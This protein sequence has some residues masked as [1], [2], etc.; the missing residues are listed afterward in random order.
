MCFCRIYNRRP[1][2]S[3]KMSPNQFL[4][5]PLKL[6]FQRESSLKKFNYEE[7]KRKIDEE[8]KKSLKRVHLFSPVR[9]SVKKTRTWQKEATRL[10]YFSE[11]FFIYQFKRNMLPNFPI[12]VKLCDLKCKIL[13][14]SFD[15]NSLK[16]L[17]FK[18]LPFIIKSFEAKKIIDAN[19][20]FV[21][22]IA[23][24]KQKHFLIPETDLKYFQTSK[25]LKKWTFQ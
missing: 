5:E 20:Y 22:K 3:L 12:L 6:A 17:K 7:N 19:T 16:I 13:P 1:H 23:N 25:K 15:L 24:F 2:T 18:K 9:I 4:K 8:L 21:V 14:G 10:K 11:D